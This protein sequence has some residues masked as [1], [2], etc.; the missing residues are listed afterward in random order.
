M[1]QKTREIAPLTRMLLA[2]AAGAT[3]ALALY[4]VAHAI[5]NPDTIA[6]SDVRAYESVLKGDD[7]LVI[8][9][10]N[11]AYGS[12]PDEI[13]SDAFLGRFFRST[14]EL[15][16]VEPFAFNDKGYGVGIFSFYWNPTELAAASI[17]FEDP[18]SEGYS[19]TLQGKVGVFTGTVPSISSGAITWADNTN[20]HDLLFAHVESLARKFENNSGWNDDADFDDLIESP[21]GSPQLTS[22]GIGSGEEYFSNAM[23]QLQSMIPS[24]F[25]SGLSSPD[26][27]E[28]PAERGFADELDDF[29]LN[30]W[31]DTHF[32]TLATTYD[33]PKRTITSLIATFFMGLIAFFSAG[34]LG[35]HPDAGGF[36]LLTMAFT[37]PMFGAINFIPLQLVIMISFVLGVLGLGWFFYL[38]RV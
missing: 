30:N 1:K 28:P 26:F 15:K 31:V 27:S 10:Y 21:G 36:A 24:I 19:V 33:A 38:R 12:L 6:I 5:D 32:N 20:T 22:E 13:I 16:N 2:L 23:P 25:S 9:E 3:A 18:N 29:W 4:G 7:L 17:E 11:L 37:L 34:L 35:R 8:V 14:T